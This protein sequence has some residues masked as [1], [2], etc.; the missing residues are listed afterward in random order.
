VRWLVAAAVLAGCYAPSPAT[1]LP[2]AT[3]GDCPSGQ[4]CDLGRQL[5]SPGDLDAGADVAIDAPQRGSMWAPPVPLAGLN[6]ADYETDPALSADGLELFF[7]SDRPGGAGALDLYRATR[8]ST[9]A[10]FGAPVPVTELETIDDDLAAELAP[11]G[12]TIYFRRGNEIYRAAR[13][14]VGA[15]F[16]SVQREGQLSTGFIDSNPTIAGD[17][18]TASTTRELSNADKELVMYRRD[19]TGQGWGGG[20]VAIEIDTPGIE[21]GGELDATGFGML[22]HSDRP[23]GMGSTDIWFTSRTAIPGTWSAPVPVTELN[24]AGI[25]SDPSGDATWHILVFERD[26]DLYITTR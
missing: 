25:E 2:C 9:S 18:L 4:D 14:V 7:S 1:G 11:D 15:P 17:N 16:G 3:N 10:S 6:T 22:F 23:G 20:R 21:S 24:T 12:L 13:P 19:N 5:C 26:R 8:S